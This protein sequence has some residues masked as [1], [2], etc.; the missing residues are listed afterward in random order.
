MSPEPPMILSDDVLVA[1]I[2]YNLASAVRLAQTLQE[3]LGDAQA[4]ALS[5][6]VGGLYLASHGLRGLR[7]AV[8]G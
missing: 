7:D 4:Q 8:H 2:D 3:R 5:D 1:G 6:L